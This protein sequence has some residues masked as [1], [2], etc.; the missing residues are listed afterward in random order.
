MSLPDAGMKRYLAPELLDILPPDDPQAIHSRRDLRRINR[1]MF[2]V[3]IMRQLLRRHL[4]GPPRRV[5]ELGG[6][7]GHFM[8]QLARATGWRDVEFILVDRQD[9]VTRE[10][11]EEFRREKWQLLMFAEDVFEFLARGIAADV[12]TANLFLHHFSETG[13]SH[14][15]AR[16]S[17][18]A[19]VLIACEPRRNRFTLAAS[20]CVALI[21]GN[22]VTRHDAAASVRAGFCD[23]ELS[24][25]WPAS[26]GWELYERG[27]PPF[28]HCF[29]AH[30]NFNPPLGGGSKTRSVLGEGTK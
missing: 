30:R 19:P 23:R 15:F 18:L 28:S 6:G 25:L 12:I 8:L 17:A 2:Q 13:L 20:H 26:G 1:A 9:I 11:R 27:A 22:R 14:L 5:I 16:A 10:T 29:V 21:G 4:P 24:A 3:A 7:D